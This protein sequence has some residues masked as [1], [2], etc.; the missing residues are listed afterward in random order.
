MRSATTLSGP[1]R[2]ASLLSP[3]HR[4][5]WRGVVLPVLV[6]VLAQILTG[7]DGF[8]SDSIASPTRIAAAFGRAVLDGSLLS[9]TGQTMAAVLAG[10]VLG[11]SAGLLLGILL[12]LSRI[13]DNLLNVTIESIRPI[14]SAAFIPLV[15]L[16]FGFGF[17]MEIAV[18]AVGALFPML[19]YARSA[20]AGT[21][22]R[23][24]ELSRA[25]GLGFA[26]RVLKIVL[27]AALPRIFVGFRLSAALALV[28]GITVEI[29]VNPIG[30]GSGIMVAEQTLQPDMVF[31]LLI[32]VGFVGWGMNA[33]MLWI[34]HQVFAPEP[35]SA[36]P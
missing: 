28:I 18:V 26:D 3:N 35:G 16:V 8:R 2:R 24:L 11:A 30:L 33:G 5:G 7:A 19:I 34:Q 27:P 22:P 17:T 31:A 23:L 9:L 21:E 29:S 4:F 32:W 25:L 1:R 12:G 10:L 14:P 15:L 6:L 13:L 20:V 36:K